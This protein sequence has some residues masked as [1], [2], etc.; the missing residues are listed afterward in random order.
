MQKKI[1]WTNGTNNEKSPRILKNKKKESFI[2]NN[3]WVNPLIGDT[4]N[5]NT[6]L[7]PI[8]TNLN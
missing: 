7:T 3:I 5:F 2:D 4:R 1:K 8:T 6:F